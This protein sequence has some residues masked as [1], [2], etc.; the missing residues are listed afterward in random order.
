MIR[1]EMK[2]LARSRLC[3]L[4][5]E[6]TQH[7]LLMRT[8][9]ESRAM[10]FPPR[11]ERCLR[12][13]TQWADIFLSGQIPEE[14]TWCRRLCLLF[15]IWTS[16]ALFCRIPHRWDNPAWCRKASVSP[17]TSGWAYMPRRCCWTL[18]PHRRAIHQNFRP[19]K[20]NI[21]PE[22]LSWSLWYCRK[23][24]RARKSDCQ[25]IPRLWNRFFRLSHS[26]C[27]RRGAKGRNRGSLAWRSLR[28]CRRYSPDYRNH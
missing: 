9:G 24:G 19:L 3:R 17:P 10:S 20:G 7:N 8:P 23:P 12:N 27:I 2:T 25:T 16:R 11:W 4:G 6:H 28:R 1:R 26:R 18:G 21:Q 13:N 22:A 14:G 5:S 15:Q